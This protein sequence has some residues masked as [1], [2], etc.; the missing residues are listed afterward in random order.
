[1]IFYGYISNY[2]ITR[3]ILTAREIV[4]FDAQEPICMN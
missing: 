2:L 1:M 4:A 3:R